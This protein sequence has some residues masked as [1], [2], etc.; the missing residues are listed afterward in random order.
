MT[1][2]NENSKSV[3]LKLWELSEPEDYYKLNNSPVFM[4]LTV[5]LFDKT[6]ISLC[7]YGEQNGDLMRDP[8][9]IFWKNENGDFYPYYYRNDY[10]GVEKYSGKIVNNRLIVSNKTIQKD[11]TEFSNLWLSNIKSQQEI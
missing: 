7:H 8:E 3:L 10:V 1:K 11:Q 2:V 6:S 9:M 5:E 4:S